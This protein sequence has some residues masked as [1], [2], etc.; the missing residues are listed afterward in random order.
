MSKPISITTEGRVTVKAQV[1]DRAGNLSAPKETTIQIDKTAPTFPNG[2]TTSN[3]T[4]SGFTIN[5]L[6]TDAI[7]GNSDYQGKITYKYK[8]TK[9]GSTTSEN[10]DPNYTGTVTLSGL[11]SYTRYNIEVT[12]TDPA[13]NSAN[14]STYVVTG[15]NGGSTTNPPGTTDPDPDNPDKP[16]VDPDNPGGGNNPGGGDNP[17]GN[18]PGGGNTG[19]LPG[20][21]EDGSPIGKPGET[22]IMTVTAVTGRLVK[23][24]Y[25][26]GKIRVLV[27]DGG[28]AENNG[29]TNLYYTITDINGNMLKTGQGLAP[30]VS[31]EFNREGLYTIRAWA[32][33]NAGE[34]TGEVVSTPLIIDQTAPTPPTINLTGTI[35]PINQDWHKS[36]VTVTI[37][38]GEDITSNIW[39]VGYYVEGANEIVREHEDG[40]DEYNPR[41][42]YQTTTSASITITLDRK[43]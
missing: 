27:E 31:F 7:S 10:I 21:M 14:T 16:P 4:T 34:R 28:L 43:E 18:N 5:T 3:V 1:A 26:T 20:W 36:N 2:I 13:G 8:V 33:N 29:T 25:Y 32:T 12:A 39:G 19:D 23:N 15:S 6:A 17:G 9:Q 30:S 42:D 11:T 22:P 37:T 24:K 41:I 35:S 38:P 40:I